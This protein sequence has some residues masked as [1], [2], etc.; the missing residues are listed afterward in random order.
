MKPLL[1]A[2]VVL[3]IALL[4]PYVIAY[5]PVIILALLGLLWIANKGFRSGARRPTFGDN[6]QE[7]GLQITNFR[8]RIP[9]DDNARVTFRVI[10]C[11][12]VQKVEHGTVPLGSG[13][14]VSGGGVTL[15][16]G[17]V[18]VSQLKLPDGTSIRSTIPKSGTPM[19]I[20]AV[21]I[22]VAAGGLAY[23]RWGSLPAVSWESVLYPLISAIV[24]FL[25]IC[26]IAKRLFR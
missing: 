5:L 8:V 4:L 24:P 21:V 19:A 17:V 2:L 1:I 16:G 15:P 14:T 26:F 12:L 20:T 6:A 11:R 18:Q 25:I 7:P 22:V 13:D 10:T 3:V 9:R 23:S